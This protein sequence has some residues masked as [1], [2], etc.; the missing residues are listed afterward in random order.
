MQLTLWKLRVK[1]NQTLWLPSPIHP[2]A[3]QDAVPASPSPSAEP[4]AGGRAGPCPGCPEDLESGNKPCWTPSPGSLCS[5]TL[6]S[7]L[8]SCL[9]ASQPL[10]RLHTLLPSQFC[11]I[12]TLLP[13]VKC[14]CSNLCD[15]GCPGKRDIS[16][17]LGRACKSKPAVSH[18][19]RR[20]GRSG[21]PACLHNAASKASPP[22]LADLPDA[23]E[24][25][26][27]SPPPQS[28]PWGQGP[29]AFAATR[30][31]LLHHRVEQGDEAVGRVFVGMEGSVC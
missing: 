7:Q 5:V 24:G 1:S 16:C 6:Q 8:T 26:A 22:A 15:Q 31:P 12:S 10:P 3:R 27:S 2:A 19:Q 29:A 11:V 9:T 4:C 30:Q 17:L 18:T 28:P 25:W 21:T 13:L 23:P 14:D 20:E